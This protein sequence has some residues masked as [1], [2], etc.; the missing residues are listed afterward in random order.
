MSTLAE[1]GAFVCCGTAPLYYLGAFGFSLYVRPPSREPARSRSRATRALF[2][3]SFALSLSLLALVLLEVLDSLSP[4][5]RWWL[6]RSHLLAHL[7]LL[8]VGLPH[9]QLTLLTAHALGL[10]HD[11]A[12]RVAVLPLLIWIYVFYSLGTIFPISPIGTSAPASTLWALPA[13]CLSRA[14]VIGVAL[15]AFVSGTGAVNAPAGALSRRLHPATEDDLRVAERRLLLDLHALLQVPFL[16]AFFTLCLDESVTA[17]ARHHRAV[18]ASYHSAQTRPRVTTTDLR[19][20]TARRGP[21]LPQQQLPP[22]PSSQAHNNISLDSA[23]PP[24]GGP[25]RPV[26]LDRLFARCLR[27]RGDATVRHLPNMASGRRDGSPP[28]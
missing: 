3:L 25:T 13:L 23:G 14:G 17:S 18:A 19:G 22:R 2:S 21:N 12:S 9:A 16:H 24:T 27:A 26:Q 7:A 8:V 5:S 28:S 1:V 15:C 11:R 20:S 4:H 10:S 6:W